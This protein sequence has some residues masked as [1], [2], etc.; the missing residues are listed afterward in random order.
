MP[1]TKKWLLEHKSALTDP[2]MLLCANFPLQGQPVLHVQDRY[3]I[4]DFKTLIIFVSAAFLFFLTLIIWICLD[5][6]KRRI[7]L[8][9]LKLFDGSLPLRSTS[10]RRELR[11]HVLVY[12]DQN[13]HDRYPYLISDFLQMIADQSL[14]ATDLGYVIGSSKYEIAEKLSTAEGCIFLMSNQSVI[15]NVCNFCFITAIDLFIRYY[16]SLFLIPVL[17][18]SE[19][20]LMENRE[21]PK[22]IKTFLR[23]FKS[24]D[25][26]Q[27]GC[28][29]LEELK[30]PW[31]RLEA[32]MT[33][34]AHGFPHPLEEE[35]PTV[36]HPNAEHRN[37]DRPIAERPNEDTRNENRRITERPN[38]DS[39]NSEPPNVDHRI[40]ERPNAAR[41]I[42][43]RRIE[44]SPLVGNN[45]DYPTS[46]VISGEEL[47]NGPVSIDDTRIL[48]PAID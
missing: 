25:I 9:L 17:V 40:A 39:R 11:H 35:P 19:A 27:R 18:D 37:E 22:D 46:V 38:E 21:T 26:S 48:V 14:K 2:D 34:Q 41:R 28:D 4:C 44:A 15:S 3:L 32:L 10:E 8:R 13:V 43:E 23:L 1:P 42:A 16:H 29:S 45:V 36:E 47:Q 5:S 30:T 20:T 6:Y 7:L 24:I 33:A 31:H 12:A